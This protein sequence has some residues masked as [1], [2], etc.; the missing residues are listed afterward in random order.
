MSRF[1]YHQ[2]N[3][4]SYAVIDP[5]KFRFAQSPHFRPPTPPVFSP[6]KDPNAPEEPSEEDK[7]SEEAEGGAEGEGTK[8]AGESGMSYLED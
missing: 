6:P 5:V 3:A 7:G 2:P 1:S 4:Y 8:P